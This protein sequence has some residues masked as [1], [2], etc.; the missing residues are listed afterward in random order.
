MSATTTKVNPPNPKL[1][2]TLDLKKLTAHAK[3]Q[4]SYARTQ[5]KIRGDYTV[6]IAEEQPNY[7]RFTFRSK[8]TNRR[9]TVRVNPHKLYFKETSC[10][11][12]FTNKAGVCA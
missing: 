7:Y 3:R 1:W 11:A 2:K 10:N 12:G 6:A 9:I 5:A 4:Q 8:K